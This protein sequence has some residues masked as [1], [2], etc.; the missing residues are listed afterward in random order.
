MATS[1]SAERNSACDNRNNNNI[2]KLT[3]CVTLDG[4]LGHLAAFQDI[5]DAN[6]GTRASGTPGYDATI[7]YVVA[8]LEAAGYDPVVQPFNFVTYI[9]TAPS[10]FEQIS[11]NPTVYVEDF[12][13]P[14]GDFYTMSYSGSGDVTGVIEP[15]ADIELG[16]GNSSTSGCEAEDFAGFTPGNIALIQRG[17][18]SFQLKAE[19]AIAAGATAVIIFNQ[20]NTEG[21]TGVIAGTLSDGFTGDIPVIGI[22]YDLGVEFIEN[23]PVTARIFTETVRELNTSFNVLAELEGRNAD[24][25]VMA[26]AHLDSVE[27]GPGIQDNGSGSAAILEVAVQMAN[28]RP[29]NTVRFGWWGAEEAGLVGSTYYIDDLVQQFFDGVSDEALYI[30]LYLNFDMIASPNYVFK[31]YDGDDSDGEGA[32]PG[33]DGSADIEAYF[34][35]FYEANGIPFKGTDFSG[36]SDYGQFIFW[37]IPAGGLFTGAEEIKTPA[38]AEIWGGTA[39]A[40]LDPCYHDACDTFDNLSHYALDVNSDAVAASV[41]HYAMTTQAINGV[42]GKG[43]FNGENGVRQLERLG[44]HYQR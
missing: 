30:A 17:L 20:G 2:N 8:T 13:T 1:A 4:V 43:N 36:R 18:C 11:P 37:G 25:V 39:G 5:A 6:G 9:E 22:T 40:Q 34:E 3:E 7:D 19:N 16:L 28:T 15:I 38:E 27:E 32:G 14:P 41:L 35:S 29:T 12:L 21:R 42:Q 31:I 26:G 44:S 33:P 24:N 23:A 10:V